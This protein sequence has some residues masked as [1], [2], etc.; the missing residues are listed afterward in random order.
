MDYDSKDERE[1]G[2]DDKVYIL[3]VGRLYRYDE[4]LNGLWYLVYNCFSIKKNEKMHTYT[5]TMQGP[6]TPTSN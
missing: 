5:F 1:R 3:I 2:R 4:G 6:A